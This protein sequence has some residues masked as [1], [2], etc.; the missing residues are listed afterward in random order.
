M[1]SYVAMVRGINVGGRAKV[2]MADLRT[3]FSGLGYEDVRSYIQSGN[4][5]FRT[6]QGARGLPAAI[7][8]RLAEDLGLPVKVVIRTSTELA[9][10][11]ARNP[12]ADGS[13]DT[14]GLHVTFLAASPTAAR[15]RALDPG[16]HLPDEFRV[17]GREVYV[18]CPNGY[19]RTKLNNAYFERALDVVATTRNVKTVGELI[20]L[21]S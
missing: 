12:L 13:R 19:G 3:A 17:V 15:A 14:G 18:H 8:A 7:E 2:A 9:T 5:V 11:L 1:T 4:V 21:S 20:R 10:I 6:A 16:A